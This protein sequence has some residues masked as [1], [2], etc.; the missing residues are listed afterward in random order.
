MTSYRDAVDVDTILE[1]IHRFAAVESP[2]SH[3]AGVNGV[4]D[5][6]AGWFEGT[7]AGLERFKVDSGLSGTAAGLNHERPEPLHQ[8]S[9]ERLTA[10][11][12]S[13]IVKR[14]MRDIARRWLG[15]LERGY[16]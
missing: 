4:L 12:V 1:D 13:R 7:G 11:S 2:T 5:I 9:A 16:G 6:I 10:H 14:A 3:P 15:R 8:I